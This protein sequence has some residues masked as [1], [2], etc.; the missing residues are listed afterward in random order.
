MAEI[1]LKTPHGI[2]LTARKD[3]W[4]IQPAVVFAGLSAFII[5]AT[6]AAFQGANY[7]FGPYLSPFYSP[8]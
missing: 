7:R 1:N 8:T 3:P 5:Y 4:W 2:R 6:W